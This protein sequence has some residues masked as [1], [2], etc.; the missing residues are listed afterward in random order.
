M[1]LCTTTRNLG[2]VSEIAGSSSQAGDRVTQIILRCIS[3]TGPQ[4]GMRWMSG[5][6]WRRAC[7]MLAIVISSLIFLPR[8]L[9][10][11]TSTNLPL[12]LASGEQYAPA[13]V[14]DGQGGAFVIWHDKRDNR[15]AIYAQ[16]L[17]LLSQPLWKPDGILIATAPK[18]QLALMAISDGKNGVLIFW[19]DLRND[20]GDIYGQRVEASGNLLWGA[21]GVEVNRATGKQAEPQAVSDGEGGAF[22]VWRDFKLSHED[23]AVQRIDGNGKILFEPAGRIV[24]QGLNNQTLGGVT[25]TNDRGFIAVWIDNS[26]LLGS[27]RVAAQRFDAKANPVWKDNVL[28]TTTRST[29]NSPVAYFAATNNGSAFVIWSDDR[30]RNDDLFAQKINATGAIQWGVSGVTVCKASNDQANPQII[31]DGGD[32]ILVAWEDQR[33]GKTDIYA[34]AVNAAGQTRWQSDGVIIVAASQEQTQPE[35]IP[36]GDGGMICVW[37]DERNSGT[38][39][40]AQR[41][42]KNGKALW[43]SNGIFITPE[44][45][46]KQR[47]AILAPSVGSNGSLVVW[48]DSRRGNEDIFAQA[49]KSEGTLANVPP[50]IISSPVTE[51]TAGAPYNYQIKA[52]DYDSSDP[53]RLELMAPAGKWL[54]VDN[55]KL[56]L[57]GTPGVSDAGEIAVTVVV[58]DKLGAQVTQSFNLK[59]IVTNRPPQITSKPDTVAT[60]DQLYGYQIVANDPDPGEVLTYAL[61]TDATWLRLDSGNKISGTPTNEQV[62]NYAVTLRVTDKLGFAATQK[63]SLQVKNVND[64]PAFTSK[65]DTVA[66]EGQLYSYQFTAV[67]PDHSDA[68]TYS[69]QTNATWLQLTNGNK[70]IGTPTN[71]NVGSHAVTLRATD[72]QGVSAAQSFSLRVKNVNNPPVFTSKADTVATEDQLYSYK[73]TATDPDLGDALTYSLQSDANWLKL[74][75]DNKLTGTPTN[76]HVGS[77]TVTLR[78]TD[79]QNI[80]VSQNFSLRVKNVNDPPV[81]TS[82]PDTVATVDSLYIYRPTAADIDRG[83]VVQIIKRAAP[84]WLS[85]NTNTRTLQ[86]KPNSQQAGTVHLVSLQARD[87]AGVAVEQNFRIRVVSLAPPDVTAPAAPQAAQVEPASWSANKKFTLRW[88]NPFDPSRVT[89]AYYKIGTAPAH[90]QD[91]VFVASSDGVTIAQLEL[92]ATRE[93]KT[94]I[95]LWLVDGRGNVDFRTAVAINYRYD[96]TPPTAPQNL[97]PHLQWNRGDSLLL[98]WTPATDASGGIRRY[99]FFLDGKFFGFV[100]GDAGSFPL[101]LQLSEGA[102]GWTFMAEDSAGNLGQWVGASFKVDRTP[103]ALQHSA[104]DTAL[105]ASD[106]ELSMQANDAL[107]GIREVRLYYRAAGESTYRNKNLPTANPATS[108]TIRLEAAEVASKG[109]EYFFEAADSAGN[110][111]RWPAANFHSLPVSSASVVAP[112]PFVV[113]RYQLFS[114]PYLLLNDSPAR[115]LEDDLGSYDQTVWRLFRYQQNEGN[116]EFGKPNF[117]NFAPGRAYWLI[118]TAPQ[119]F[120]AGPARSLRTNAPFELKLQPGWNLVATP[121]DFPTAWP[122]VQKPESVEN[123]LWAFDGTK[124]V[125]QQNTLQPWQGYF[126]R[127]L[128]SQPQTISIAPAAANGANKATAVDWQAQLRVSDGEFS[129]EANYL[130]VAARAGENWDSHDL[131]EPPTIGEHVSLYFDHH[132]WPRYGGKFTR[133]FRPPGDGVQQWSFV[134]AVSRPGLPVALRWNLSGNFPADRIFILQD[135][136][137]NLRREIQP[138]EFHPEANYTF[139]ATAQPRRFI[140]WAGKKEQLAEAG[141]LQNLIPAAF[142]L[143]PSYPNPLRLAELPQAGVIRFGLPNAGTVRLTIFDLAGRTVRK[144]VNGESLN[145]GYHEVRWNGRDDAGR[146]VTAGIYI[147]RLEAANFSASHKLILLR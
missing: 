127:N 52:L 79:R 17:N 13:L 46:A 126:L 93:G 139:R 55:G 49:L 10:S 116:V 125:D 101:I 15:T 39:I 115:L 3:S 41:L 104:A 27:P 110:R 105:A 30:N 131:S 123:N 25:A 90:N 106:L 85:W 9:H 37:S 35:I 141:A 71:A 84:E 108:F 69:L 51:A 44:G 16:R 14:S 5:E 124:Y 135:I 40:A 8:H 63:F 78:A 29:Q 43:E 122:A 68:L 11:Q 134:I 121:F 102:H 58:K 64:P 146:A 81:F 12:V 145:A 133:D 53:L 23:I 82:P 88:Q 4:I 62:G 86:G 76:D 136:A 89:G 96:V 28:V 92:L 144:L 50:I 83:E 74:T 112:A 32:G 147:Y 80:S 114:V 119:S 103:P 113:N 54:Q 56:Q 19:Q 59:V 31:G 138:A 36:D 34:Q 128:D 24:A 87:A 60:E 107:A 95:Y 77:Y 61:E 42:D 91:G 38:N 1:Q 26:L 129:D 45:G 20:A 67:D 132:D 100:D 109:L 97:T 72:R 65:P 120:D 70:L 98:Q 143:A 111:G 73:F 66:T 18:D 6:G 99:H 130:G 117:E 140:W 47:P 142:E 57:F 118:T 2:P 33:S 7:T 22:V 21:T 48:E 137:G 75:A 94:P